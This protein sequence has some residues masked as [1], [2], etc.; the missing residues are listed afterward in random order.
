MIGTENHQGVHTASWCTHSELV[1]TQRA[2]AHT[3]SC[4]ERGVWESSMPKKGV[5]SP[6]FHASHLSS[7][8]YSSIDSTQWK[9]ACIPSIF[10]LKKLCVWL[11]AVHMSVWL[12]ACKHLPLCVGMYCV[13]IHMEARNWCSASS[14]IALHLIWDKILQWAWS[15]PIDYTSYPVSSRDRPVFVLAST[16][17]TDVY[18]HTCM[19]KKPE[20]LIEHFSFP[21]TFSHLF[22]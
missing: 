14:S 3:M 17:V 18:H 12:C 2:G 15:S 1:H 22:I 16:S 9:Q 20:D 21:Q 8:H 19:P 4:T 10:A 13:H 11:C 5:A 6:S 7:F